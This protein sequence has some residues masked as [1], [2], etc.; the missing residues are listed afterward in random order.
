MIAAKTRFMVVVDHDREEWV[1][2]LR[3]PKRRER[4]ECG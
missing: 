1:F 3:N 4:A 2:C